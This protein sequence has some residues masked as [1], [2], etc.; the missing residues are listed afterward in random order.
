MK[1]SVSF[2]WLKVSLCVGLL[3]LL[4]PTI[5][6]AAPEDEEKKVYVV[7]DGI[8]AW[9]EKGYPL[10]SKDFGEIKVIKYNKQLKVVR[11]AG[12]NTLS[13][14]PHGSSSMAIC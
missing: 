2:G 11:G 14:S 8:A 9:A 12:V 4:G 3:M 6:I 7:D 10:F 1:Q 13:A 5:T